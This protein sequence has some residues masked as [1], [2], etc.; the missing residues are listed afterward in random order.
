MTENPKKDIIHIKK[1]S[2]IKFEDIYRTE[3]AFI[4]KNLQDNIL[5]LN[6]QIDD[7]IAEGILIISSSNNAQKWFLMRMQEL[8]EEL[9]KY[10]K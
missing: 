1:L 3:P 4:I 6:E 2:D 9:K 5:K 8:K 7:I 10:D